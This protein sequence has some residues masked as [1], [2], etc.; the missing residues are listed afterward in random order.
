M[1]EIHA[2]DGLFDIVIQ[3]GERG[4]RLVVTLE[5]SASR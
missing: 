3:E 5:A 1:M 2:K 4:R